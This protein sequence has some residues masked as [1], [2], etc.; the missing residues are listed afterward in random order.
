MNQQIKTILLLGL[1]TTLFVG[2]G[3]LMGPKYL[4]GFFILSLILNIGTY[5]FSDRIVLKMYRAREV[6]KNESPWLHEVVAEL[7][8]KAGIP[9]PKVCV[10]ENDSPNAFAT[11]RTPAKGVVAVTTGIQKILS[12]RELRGVLAHE[13]AHIKN[14]DTLVATIAAVIATA[15]SYIGNVVQWTA[16]FGGNQN[17]EEKGSPAA[18]LAMAFLAPLIAMLLQ[19]GIS[20]S[21]EYYADQTG[22]QISG[23]PES[24]ASALEK[25]ENIS[26]LT[27]SEPLSGRSPA[28]SSLFIINPFSGAGG[29]LKLFSTHPATAERIKRLRL[30]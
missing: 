24:L 16:L 8:Q 18:S 7:A 4:Y 29:L 12:H 20:R 5:F 3:G 10:M 25:M 28:T 13:I 14:R 9:K 26:R 22:A 15:I 1:L 23:D 27:E 11:G 21:R 17:D 30:L 6:D 19:F 2:L